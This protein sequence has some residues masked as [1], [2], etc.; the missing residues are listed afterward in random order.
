M[1]ENL[2]RE[3]RQDTLQ[4]SRTEERLG[5]NKTLIS[6]FIRDV[7][8]NYE[9]IVFSI[10]LETLRAN[11]RPAT[12]RSWTTSARRWGALSELNSPGALAGPQISENFREIFQDSLRRLCRN[13]FFRRTTSSNSR[14]KLPGSESVKSPGLPGEQGELDVNLE[15]GGSR[16][17]TFKAIYSEEPKSELVNPGGGLGNR[18]SATKSSSKLLRSASPKSQ[19][20]GAEAEV[21]L[22]AQVAEKVEIP[23]AQ[24]KNSGGGERRQEK[25]LP[26]FCLTRDWRP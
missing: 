13:S 8:E 16:P 14:F 18:K 1:R 21:Q 22:E 7:E 20:S 9:K 5:L 25:K 12:T 6:D 10:E 24:P 23:K 19:L 26:R 17:A 15:A 4:I 3:S 11:H 2:A